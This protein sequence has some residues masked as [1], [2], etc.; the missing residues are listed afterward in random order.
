MQQILGISNCQNWT[1]LQ[2]K[3]KKYAQV[4]TSSATES[5]ARYLKY[6][7]QMFVSL[8]LTASY[9]SGTGRCFSFCDQ[10]YFSS[11]S[12]CTV[13][14]TTRY[15]PANKWGPILSE[16]K[17]STKCGRLYFYLLLVFCNFTPT[18][19]KKEGSYSLPFE[20]ISLHICFF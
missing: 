14:A 1:K 7:R 3:S 12:S 10:S 2:R 18:S 13:I 9:A 4:R 16:L 6:L 17:R 8:A 19:P 11:L 5:A 20:H 15:Y